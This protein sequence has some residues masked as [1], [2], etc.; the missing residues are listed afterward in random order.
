MVQINLSTLKTLCFT[1]GPFLLP[2]LIAYYR[3]FKTSRAQA[4]TI[5][6]R[7][8]PTH[9]YR[10]L[11][12][13]FISTFLFFLSTFPYFAPENIFLATSSRI[14]TPNDVLFN[15]LSSLRPTNTLTPAD[16]H[17]KPRIASIDA[18]CLYLQYG[19]EILHSCPF[20]LSDEPLSYFWYALPTLLLPHILHLFALGAATS[21]AIAGKEGNRWRNSA[22]M[23]GVGLAV[24]ECYVTGTR[25]WKGNARSL[26]AQ[27][28]QHWHWD[29]RVWRGIGIAVADAVFAGL[30][31]ASATNRLF[32]VPPTAGERVEGALKVLEGARGKM[33]A[34]GIVR[35]VVVRDEGL[36]RR[37]EGYWRKEGAVMAEV[38][39]EREVLEGI[40]GALG[41]GRVQVSK[42]EEEARRYADAIV[43]GTSF[44]QLQQQ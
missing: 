34:L 21:S 44:V 36:R 25:N 41:S 4:K 18:R 6:I 22:V 43:S 31:Y 33:A 5:P 12:I 3:S 15:R 28:L 14:Q 40:R 20:C 32:V 13:L 1:L 16:E 8:L 23:L 29:M 37:G 9:I 17:L 38:L 27:D 30:L 7:P 19:P 24:M 35:N 10:S 26:R 2:R 42:V 11:N 39:E